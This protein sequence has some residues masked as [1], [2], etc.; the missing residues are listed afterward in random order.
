MQVGALSPS[1][2][3]Q[4]LV[5]RALRA[6]APSPHTQDL[7]IK[8]LDFFQLGEPLGSLGQTSQPTDRALAHGLQPLHGPQK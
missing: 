4:C 2:E 3:L 8:G 1:P 7:K 5:R 6:G